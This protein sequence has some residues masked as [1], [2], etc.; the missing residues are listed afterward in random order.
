M[1]DYRYPETRLVIFTKAPLAGYCKTRL[2]PQLGEQGAAQLQQQLIEN[3]LE[4]LC[5]PMLCPTEL[6]C[7]PDTTHPDL[8]KLAKLYQLHLYQ[9]Q[10]D[11][12][13]QKMYHAMAYCAASYTFII[14]SDCPE[15]SSAYIEAG[16]E[17]LRSGQDAVI[18]P[19]EDGGYVLLG[20]QQ[21]NKA[22]FEGIRWGTA[23]VFAQTTQKM[24]AAGM[25][26]SA[27]ATQWDLDDGRD[28]IRYQRLRSA[29][30]G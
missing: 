15:I 3:C 9:Q 10:G 1:T 4:R 12:L 30:M 13:G 8:Q 22:L 23:Q 2:I 27:L 19:A 14:G 16:I 21:V 11:D 25:R 7:S 26:W 24:T 28:L 5:K 29:Q 18:G 20:V 6:W 17:Q